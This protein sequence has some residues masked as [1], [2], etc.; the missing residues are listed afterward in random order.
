MRSLDF[1]EGETR[2]VE[3]MADEK[4]YDLEVKA[5]EIE[6]VKTK[7]FGEV[8][9]LKLEPKAKFQGLFV[10]KGRM[11]TWGSLDDRFVAVKIVAKIPLAS[12]K[13]L[14][15]EVHGPGD[16]RW[17]RETAAMLKD[18]GRDAE[19]EDVEAALKELDAPAN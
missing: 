2:F 4:L 6:T 9:A 14:L 12:V 1:K 19:E 17:T 3:V 16:D 15:T 11:I 7:T 10:R 5:Q 18:K 8:K 13:V